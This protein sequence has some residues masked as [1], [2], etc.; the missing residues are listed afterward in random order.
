MP[1]SKDLFESVALKIYTTRKKNQTGEYGIRSTFEM[2][3]TS[4][5]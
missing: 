3:E 2:L 4:K 1:V 5:V